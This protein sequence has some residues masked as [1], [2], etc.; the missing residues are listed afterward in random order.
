[1]TMTDELIEWREGIGVRLMLAMKCTH[2][3]D[4]FGPKAVCVTCFENVQRV[5]EI[6]QRAAANA[7]EQG[8]AGRGNQAEK[9]ACNWAT[10]RSPQTGKCFAWC[11]CRCHGSASVTNPYCAIPQRRGA[12]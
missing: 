12:A 11:K 5:G 3:G 2:E 7:W 10:C 9:P 4:D 8:R 6:I 1:M